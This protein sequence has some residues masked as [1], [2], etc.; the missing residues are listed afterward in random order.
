[1][2]L[3]GTYAGLIEGRPSPELNVRLLEQH[4]EHAQAR[5]NHVPL[6]MVEPVVSASGA[7]PPVA[8][9]AVL[10]SF[11]RATKGDGDMLAHLK[12]L[13]FLDALP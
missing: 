10:K 8:C 1:M 5:R 2:E 9:L 11:S 7:L 3:W 4:V 13:C 12:V 6:R